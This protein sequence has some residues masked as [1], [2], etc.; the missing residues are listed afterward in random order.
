VS[1]HVRQWASATWLLGVFA[2]LAW[3]NFYPGTPHTS[4][5]IGN[6]LIGVGFAA[7]ATL[8]AVQEE[9][10]GN[11]GMFVVLTL[12]WVSGQ[13]T[14]RDV[15]VLTPLLLWV[16]CFTQVVAAAVLLRYPRARL[17]R[18]GRRF[19]VTCALL[20]GLVQVLIIVTLDRASWPTPLPPGPWPTVRDDPQLN[21]ALWQLRWIVWGVAG[22]LFLVLLVRR[23]RQLRSM[24]RKSLSP[25]LLTAAVATATIS[26]RLVDVRLPAPA[27][28]VLEI[29]RA[30]AAVAVSG[31]FVL[32]AIRM[33]L[34]RA[35]VATLA[36]ELSG[37]VSVEEVRD[38]LR[39]ALADPTLEVWY[40]IPDHAA[41]VD[42][43]GTDR[44]L[45]S[46]DAH[47]LA[48]VADSQGTPMAVVVA[49]EG[50]RRHRD[51]VDSAVAVSR[52]ALE[53]GR[54]QAS[55]RTQLTEVREARARLLHAGLEQRRRLERD[56]H[57]GAQQR[58]LAL[59]MRLAALE[60]TVTDQRTTRSIQ[61]AKEELNQALVELRDLAHGLYPVVLSQSGLD[62][63]LEAVTERLSVPVVRDIAPRRWAPD[64]ES[65]A[66]LIA[67][68]ALT[69]ACK[70]AGPSS[71]HLRIYERHEHLVV[72]VSD[73]GRGSAGLAAG[74]GV[75][76]I[77][78]RVEAVGGR[79]DVHSTVGAGTRVIAELPCG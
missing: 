58:L 57:D 21:D 34:A 7:T 4:L 39:R 46:E 8:L 5:A 77:K 51:L 22:P 10:Q 43:A 30:Y 52:L 3:G 79:L 40:W 38:A 20:L 18:V 59:G 49:D 28:L 19:I 69:N 70:H 15:G 31:A 23:W 65:T 17:D 16:A 47:V 56:L 26:V 25:I 24:E 60:T 64:L 37:S 50:L 76:A 71:I 68:E 75:R 66:Y 78:D 32:S 61:A 6:I 62:P 48:P 53:N 9:Q 11:A 36:S 42:A 2:V 54:L 35:A 45:P 12:V 1:G 72:D 14:T 44:L 33:R 73:D 67:C 41:Y 74:E 27:A 13:V 29:I 63:A 55:L